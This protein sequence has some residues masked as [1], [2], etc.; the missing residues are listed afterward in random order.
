MAQRIRALTTSSME[1]SV[2]VAVQRVMALSST[3]QG[4]EV[5]RAT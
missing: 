1:V 2:G 4:V 3:E 5:V